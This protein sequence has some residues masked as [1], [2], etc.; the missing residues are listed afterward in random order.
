[1]NKYVLF[2]ILMSFLTFN[3]HAVESNKPSK[4]GGGGWRESYGGDSSIME[5]K[6]LA[7]EVAYVLND[8]KFSN[9]F[10]LQVSSLKEIINSSFVECGSDLILNGA[11]KDAINYP[12]EKPQRVTLDCKKWNSGLS[13]VQKYRLVIHE[14]LPLAKVDD[15]SYAYSEEI[16]SF[17]QHYRYTA[18]FNMNE[19]I[20]ALS[21]CNLEKFR[22]LSDLGGNLFLLT[23]RGVN[24]LQIAAVF[25][26]DA[27]L[28][29]LIEAGL[30]YVVNEN[31]GPPH[32][33]YALI[34]NVVAEHSPQSYEK[35]L[36]TLKILTNKWPLLASLGF[37]DIQWMNTYLY[38]LDSKCYEGSTIMH[39]LATREDLMSDDLNFIKKLTNLGFS[40]DTKNSCDQTPRSLFEKNGIHI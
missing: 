34:E 8:K 25:S 4:G 32:V 38:H 39:L 29:D 5:F 3:L 11:P 10:G 26:C 24:F 27:I 20:E 15:S 21:N 17:F 14:Y 9:N 23:S 33:H 40:L 37:K 31:L 16:F 30:E 28:Q 6:H 19:M 12:N 13:T 22:T 36:N 7:K 2:A 1:M 18:N 35:A